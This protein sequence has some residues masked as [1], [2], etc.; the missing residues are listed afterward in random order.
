MRPPWALRWGKS[1]KSAWSP[2]TVLR[3]DRIQLT[4]CSWLYFIS[5]FTAL[6]NI[7]LLLFQAAATNALGGP[8]SCLSSPTSAP[9]PV[10]HSPEMGG[11]VVPGRNLF[12]ISLRVYANGHPSG[13]LQMLMD[14]NSDQPYHGSYWLG[15]VEIVV[16]EYLEHPRLVTAGLCNL[17]TQI[18]SCFCLQYL[19]L[20]TGD[21]CRVQGILGLLWVLIPTVGCCLQGHVSLPFFIFLRSTSF[22]SSA[23][24]PFPCFWFQDTSW[25]VSRWTLWLSQV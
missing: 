18:H 4:A 7:S 24:I 23:R 11:A 12:L 9:K 17:G 3:H 16:Y 15:L 13:A 10:F 19:G 5:N 22:F 2:S 20:F 8:H 6:T 14:Y 1:W 25:K 21:F